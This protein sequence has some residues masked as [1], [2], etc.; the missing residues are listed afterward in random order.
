MGI[1]EL[2]L[3]KGQP[4][5]PV[6]K[7]KPPTAEDIEAIEKQAEEKKKNG[8]LYQ[9]QAKAIEALAEAAEDE[10]AGKEALAQAQA[11]LRQAKGRR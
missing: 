10:Q 5:R 2:I 6:T 4:S 9:R 1:K 3:G 11:R 7:E 8:D